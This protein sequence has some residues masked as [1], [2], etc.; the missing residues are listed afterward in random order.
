MELCVI[1]ISMGGGKMAGDNLIKPWNVQNKENSGPKQFL[2]GTSQ[3]KLK[4]SED[5]LLIW[6]RCFRSD[7]YEANQ[8][9]AEPMIP[10][11]FSWTSRRKS[12][13]STRS[14]N[15]FLI[16]HGHDSDSAE[17][18]FRNP[19][20]N[21]GIGAFCSDNEET[22]EKEMFFFHNLGDEW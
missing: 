8:S 19:D 3:F 16:I 21:F 11:L 12:S 22:I 14:V 15:Y 13:S 1:G 10:K 18:N 2:C 6:T 7:R 9:W 5:L 4:S 20:W 17:W